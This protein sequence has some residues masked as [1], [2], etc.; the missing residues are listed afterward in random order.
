MDIMKEALK[1][2]MEDMRDMEM[3]KYREET[4]RPKRGKKS[5]NKLKKPES[6][7]AMLIEIENEDDD[8]KKKDKKKDSMSEIMKKILGE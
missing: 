6:G 4:G 7:F 2:L 5:D 1:E 3:D 8:T